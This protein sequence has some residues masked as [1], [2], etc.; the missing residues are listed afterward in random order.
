MTRRYTESASRKNHPLGVTIVAP[1]ITSD[2]S[3]S[4]A[5]NVSP[6]LATVTY[7]NHLRL[8]RKVQMMPAATGIPSNTEKYT[9]LNVAIS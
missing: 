1:C 8:R 3:Q 4:V 6:V 2:V 5:R 9:T 7:S